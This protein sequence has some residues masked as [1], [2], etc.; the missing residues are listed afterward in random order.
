MSSMLPGVARILDA[1][2]R[3]GYIGDRSI[4]TAL[5]LAADLRRPLL[6]EGE[7]GVGKTEIAKVLAEVEQARLIRLQCYEGLDAA[8]TLYEWNYP[9]QMIRVQIERGLDHEAAEVEQSIFSE[10]FLL[11][12]PLL[13]ALMEQERPPVLLIDEVD[14][15]DMEFE[16]F[17][18]EFLSEFQISIPELGVIT[19][20][21]HPY[22]VL[23]SNR[24]RE[25]SDAL[26]RRCLY[27]WIDYPSFEKEVSVIRRKVEG[28]DDVLAEQITGFIQ[29]LRSRNLVKVPGLSETLDWARCLVALHCD[30]LDPD[31]VEATLGA[32]LKDRGDIQRV[33]DEVRGLV[34]SLNLI[35]ARGVRA[36]AEAEAAAGRGAPA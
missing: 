23:T 11:K 25:L 9:K 2:N 18:L 27:L 19:A 22:V 33:E 5:Y 30:H 26:L 4:A 29:V 13:D 14:R 20:K 12:R 21:H 15:A 36:W 34:E 10:D 35:G 7:A 17:L 6:I 32:L 24:S 28:I 1:L 8:T 16:A 3:F 31:E